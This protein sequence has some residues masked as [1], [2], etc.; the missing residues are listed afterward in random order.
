[1]QA[2]FSNIAKS[3]VTG[4]KTDDNDIEEVGDANS[5]EKPEITIDKFDAL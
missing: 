4:P 1:L 3:F 2:N 5:P